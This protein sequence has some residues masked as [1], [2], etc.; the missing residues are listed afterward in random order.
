[1]S[2]VVINGSTLGN[3]LTEMLT[4]DDI[5]PGDSPSYELCKVIWLHHPLGKKIVESPIQMAQSQPREI[6]VPDSPESMVRDAFVREWEELKVDDIIYQV[7]SVARVYGIGSLALVCEEVPANEPIDPKKLADL[8]ISFSIFDPLN[9]AGSLVL[10]QNPNSIDFMKVASIAVSGVP[11]HRS[12][13]VTLMNERPVYIA[14]TSSAFGFVG[15]S[16]FQRALFPLKSFVQSMIT[17]DLVTKKAGVFIVKLKAAGAIIDAIMQAS[18]GLKRL[19]VQQATNGNV[20]S[21]GAEENVETLNMQNLD[22]AFGMARQDILEN[23]ATGAD[24]PAILLKQETF[25]EGFGEGTED[26]KM[27]ARFVDRYRRELRPVYK[28][29]DRIVMYRAWNK[30]F[31]KRV[32]QEYPEYR[33]MRYEDAFY[34]WSNSF[35]AEW[36]SLLTEPDSEKVK[37]DDVKL[38]AIV[39]VIQVFGPLLDPENKATLLMWAEDNINENKMMFQSPLTLD[40]D[41]LANYEP[42]QPGGD[43]EDGEEGDGQ[44]EPP[45]PRPFSAADSIDVVRGLADSIRRDLDGHLKMRR[46]D[47]TELIDLVGSVARLV[48]PKGTT[49]ADDAGWDESKHPRKKGGEGGGQFAPKGGGGGPSSASEPAEGKAP[50]EAGEAKKEEPADTV[51]VVVKAG[52]TVLGKLFNEP[53]S[54]EVSPGLAEKLKSDGSIEE[55]GAAS[56]AEK[57]GDQGKASKTKFGG[58]WKEPAGFNEA[59]TYAHNADVV[60]GKPANAGTSYRQ[61]LTHLVKSAGEHGYEEKLPKLKAKLVEALFKAQAKAIAANDEKGVKSLSKV[62]EA[63]QKADPDAMKAGWEAYSGVKGS[64]PALE[65]AKAAPAKKEAKAE[66]EKPAAPKMTFPPATAQEL[67]KAKKSVKLQLQYVPGAPDVPEAHAL[68]KEFNEKY[69]GKDLKTPG[70][71]EAKVND[72]KAMQAQMTQIAAASE[73]KIKAEAAEKAKKLKEQQ[74]A[75]AKA[76][77]E[78]NAAVMKDLGITEQE[79]EGFNALVSMLGKSQADVVKAFKGYEAEAKQYG[80]PIS[81]FECALVKNYTD[82]GYSAV[83]K[84]L[85]SGSWTV[86]QHVYVKMVNK[87]LQAMPRY[88]GTLHRGAQLGAEALALYKPGNV[89]EE[90]AFTST[91]ITNPFGGN[92]KFTVKAIGKRAAH[93]KKLSHYGSEDEVLFSARTF[94]KVTKVET[95]GGTTHVHM[96]E[97]DE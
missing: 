36:P 79:A 62:L 75:E 27:V 90:R 77:A 80:Y 25:A 78:K 83:N 16:V 87:A 52:T 51:K 63:T 38:K 13:T 43:G 33:G 12:R 66:P 54:L 34:K 30:D 59:Q 49:I 8:S 45:P 26:A 71:L 94:F 86:A 81:G 29:M 95:K 76:N 6:S 73:A 56:P 68:V 40:Y 2:Q 44:E 53:T 31:F 39:A 65:P 37:T 22:K 32:Q 82:G 88:E 10:N 58:L 41:A 42:P 11:Y 93:V 67:E 57:G 97:M 92:T 60:L 55:K 15:R 18:A 85:R 28:F 61:M 17:D 70:Q 19:F 35:S 84:A 21:I 74:A 3:A 9:T 14:Y 20:I 48:G 96:E 24:M 46:L 5:E 1:M 4:A 7:A 47:R 50:A 89:V 72:F 69:E 64:A 91:S 23:I